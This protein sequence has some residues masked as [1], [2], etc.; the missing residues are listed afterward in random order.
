MTTSNLLLFQAA[1]DWAIAPYAEAAPPTMLQ[2]SPPMLPQPYLNPAQMSPP[3]APGVPLYKTYLQGA[4]NLNIDFV[5]TVSQSGDSPSGSVLGTGLTVETGGFQTE[6]FSWDTAIAQSQNQ[7]RNDSW[8]QI[9]TWNDHGEGTHLRPNSA[10][11]YAYYDMAAYY[12]QYYKTGVPPT[13]TQD[14]LYY[15]HRL[16]SSSALANTSYQVNGQ[17]VVDKPNGDPNAAMQDQIWVTGLLKNAGTLAIGTGQTPS[18]FT[19]SVTNTVCNYS[20]PF[21]GNVTPQFTFTPSGSTTPEINISSAFKT[22]DSSTAIDWQD[23][24]YRAGGSTRDVIT[25]PQT[26]IPQSRCANSPGNCAEPAQ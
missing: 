11:Q 1:G 25:S 7:A 5:D 15:A 18:S 12:I 6:E 2:G 14:A 21:V 16:M 20:V 19:C 22:L 23:F 8:V 4:Y 3:P 26:D 9:V 10:S 17:T 24:L 13:I